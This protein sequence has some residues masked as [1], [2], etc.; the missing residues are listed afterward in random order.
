MA[1]KQRKVKF[2]VR[3]PNPYEKSWAVAGFDVSM[4]SISGMM[5]MFDSVLDKMRGPGW[6]SV[7]WERPVHFFDRLC[8]AVKANEIMYDLMRNTAPC[9]VPYDNFYIGVEEPWPAGIVKKAESGWLRQQAQVHGAFMGGLVKAGFCN[10]F[11]VNAQTW[12]NPIRQELGVGRPDK[13]DIKRWAIEAYDL[14]DLPDLIHHGTRGL[15]PRPES[16]KA[17]AAQPD[18]IYDAAGVLAWMSDEREK[19]LSDEVD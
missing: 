9:S 6:V 8:Q 19:F 11:E 7:R 2:P 5:L 12:K 4:T 13:F 10:V 16:S 3:Q 17:K 1:R 18:D 15:V 14:P